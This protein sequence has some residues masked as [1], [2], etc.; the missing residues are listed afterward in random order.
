MSFAGTWRAG[1][2]Y[3]QQTNGGTEN[4]TTHVFA[5][6]RE[7][8]DENTWTNGREQHTLEPVWGLGE[9]EYQGE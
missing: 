3:P 8:N 5:Y 7:L 9:G 1:G 4:Q 2:H 6:K